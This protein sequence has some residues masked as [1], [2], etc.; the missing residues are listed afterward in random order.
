MN[1]VMKT[2]R[3][4][5]RRLLERSGHPGPGP[6]SLALVLA[7]A[8]TGK[9]AFLTGIGLDA[10]LSGQRVLHVS[11]EANVDRVRDWYDDL[12]SELIRAE[13]SAVNGAEI[14]AK[15]EKERHIHSFL[16]GSFSA[17]KLDE[18]ARTL[19]ERL[20]FRPQVIVIDRLDR[21]HNSHDEVE[22]LRDL[23]ERL[24]AEL[25]VSARVYREMPDAKEG[26]LPPPS[27]QIEDLVDLA[28]KLESEG[29]RVRLHVLKDHG[30]ILD[31]NLDVLLDPT[32]LLL[33][34]EADIASR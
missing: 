21:R 18:T 34:P 5:P 12:L 23:A 1:D 6:G 2:L 10:L 4:S 24:G 28:F 19:A 3:R 29:D 17:E 14:Q 22:A 27:E 11:V 8:G 31:K 16:G 20:D 26:H 32:T 30:E 15:I 9:T 25:W 33:V 13:G 7:R